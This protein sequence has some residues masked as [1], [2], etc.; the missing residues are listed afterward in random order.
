M[1]FLKT[2]GPIQSASNFVCIDDFSLSLFQSNTNSPFLEIL[3][4]FSLIK[5]YFD[6]LL[7]LRGLIQVFS[8]FFFQ[9]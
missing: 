6:T 5:I 3:Y 2:Q 9:F 7:P 1:I 4:S 8:L